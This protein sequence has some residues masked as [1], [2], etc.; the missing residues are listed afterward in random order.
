LFKAKK[1]L[2]FLKSLKMDQEPPRI[3]EEC[4]LE[5]PYNWV[6]TTNC[7]QK[8]K[9]GQTCAG[10]CD[11]EN[12]SSW[13]CSINLTSNCFG[14]C[15]C[16]DPGNWNDL[17]NRDLFQ[18]ETDHN[19][20]RKDALSLFRNSMYDLN[21]LQQLLVSEVFDI[22]DI[23]PQLLGSEIKNPFECMKLDKL[24]LETKVELRSCDVCHMTY[25]D[26]KNITIKRCYKCF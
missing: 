12:C 17:L 24:Q 11:P 20:Q 4:K 7:C 2:F 22:S 8:L 21:C 18:D 10:P 13:V 26:M 23:Y 25:Y 16:R 5:F 9:C 15:G 6:S 14:I 1:K 3:C 19:N